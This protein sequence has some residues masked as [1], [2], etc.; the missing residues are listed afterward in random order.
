MHDSPGNASPMMRVDSVERAASRWSTLRFPLFALL[1]A[2][3]AIPVTAWWHSYSTSGSAA[4]DFSLTDGNGQPFVL[5][6]QRGHSVVL[7]FGYTHCPDACPTTLSRVAAALRERDVPHDARVAFVTVDPLR[8]T[9]ALLKRY[10]T[11]FNPA[12][13][14]LTGRQTELDRV[15]RDYHVVHENTPDGPNSKN[16]SVMHSTTIY[17]IGR[18]GALNG[19]GNWDDSVATIAQN[20][21]KYQ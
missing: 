4:P 21:K 14:G 5:S 6:G 17:F 15:Y 3:V 13:I 16:Y 11:I 12:F 18:S 9:P 1:L 2:L 10:V 20:L 7:F 19:F 8:D